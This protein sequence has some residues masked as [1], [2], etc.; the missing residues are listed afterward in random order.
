LENVDRKLR[1]QLI[2]DRLKKLKSL[3]NTI[4]Y[5]LLHHAMILCREGDMQRLAKMHKKIDN[6]ME[7]LNE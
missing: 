3:M 1:E 7:V 6:L 5:D 2:M 4:C